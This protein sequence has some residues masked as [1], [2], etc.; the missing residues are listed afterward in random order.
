VFQ[1]D[2]PTSERASRLR[3]LGAITAASTSVEIA[4]G[5]GEDAVRRT[6]WVGHVRFRWNDGSWSFLMS[7]LRRLRASPRLYDDGSLQVSRLSA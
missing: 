3:A 2:L 4:F 5:E 6:V 7:K 1:D